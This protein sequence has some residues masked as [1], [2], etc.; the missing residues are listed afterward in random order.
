MNYETDEL[1]QTYCI[2]SYRLCIN[3]VLEFM[4]NY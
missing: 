4:L 3:V 1:S 2:Y